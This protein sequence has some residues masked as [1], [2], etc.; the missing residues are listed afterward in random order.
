MI[1][2]TQLQKQLQQRN[3]ITRPYPVGRSMAVTLDP[4]LVRELEVD[5]LT[6]VHQKKVLGGILLELHKLTP[7]VE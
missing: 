5:D 1:V 2:M 3:R 4:N 7:K 6:F